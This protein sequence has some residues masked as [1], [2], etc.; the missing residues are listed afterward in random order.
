MWNVWNHASFMGN[1]SNSKNIWK[2]SLLERS[3][4]SGGN[5]LWRSRSAS[6][7]YQNEWSGKSGQRNGSIFILVGRSHTIVCKCGDECKRATLMQYGTGV[8]IEHFYGRTDQNLP[9]A[10]GIERKSRGN[11]FLFAVRTVGRNWW[12]N[13]TDIRYK[14]C[15]QFLQ[16][17]WG[18]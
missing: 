10:G 2:N 8:R 6:D 13:S 18:W 11:Q 5:D 1:Q 4:F 16:S 15:L 17:V 3:W 12:N 14:D 9:T 7:I